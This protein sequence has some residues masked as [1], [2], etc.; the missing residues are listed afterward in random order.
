MAWALQ[1]PRVCPGA[2]GVGA[3]REP[4]E[5]QA[6]QPETFYVGSETPAGFLEWTEASGQ[7]R[8]RPGGRLAPHGVA[9]MPQPHELTKPLSVLSS[10]K[11][12]GTWLSGS[13]GLLSQSVGSWMGVAS[14]SLPL[15][16]SFMQG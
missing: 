15:I 5:V 7:E 12:M 9:T 2:L 1:G 10:H 13:L 6:G 4:E 14:A 11:C 16:F 3:A 8:G